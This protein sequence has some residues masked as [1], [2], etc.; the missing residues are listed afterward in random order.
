VPDGLALMRQV[1][2]LQLS[3]MISEYGQ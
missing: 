3:K 1:K 2:G